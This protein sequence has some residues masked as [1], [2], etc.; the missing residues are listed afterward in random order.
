MTKTVVPEKS[1][2]ILIGSLTVLVVVLVV[3]YFVY[4]PSIDSRIQKMLYPDHHHQKQNDEKNH[5]T[6]Q[7]SQNGVDATSTSS[8]Q[9]RSP[10]EYRNSEAFED[11]FPYNEANF[12]TKPYESS[13]A[14]CHLTA[15]GMECT[16]MLRNVRWKEPLDEVFIYDVDSP[17]TRPM[18]LP[19]GPPSPCIETLQGRG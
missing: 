18:H 15:D 2:F 5:Q 3:L 16:P 8:P 7:V 17:I 14:Q 1:R 11:V 19:P 10:I 4:R 12:I 13:V 9:I 6:A